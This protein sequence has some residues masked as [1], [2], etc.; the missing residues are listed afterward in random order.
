[1]A[2]KTWLG[3]DMIEKSQMARKK[4]IAAF[5]DGRRTKKSQ[6]LGSDSGVANCVSSA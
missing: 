6:L 4:Q 5:V 2:M 1:M 3:A